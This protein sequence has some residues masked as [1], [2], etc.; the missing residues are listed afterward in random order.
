MLSIFLIT[1]VTL[2]GR[3]PQRCAPRA[4]CRAP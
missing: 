4:G 2:T 3:P 1:A